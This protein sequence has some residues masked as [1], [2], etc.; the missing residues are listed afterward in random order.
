M[1]NHLKLFIA[2]S[3]VAASGAYAQDGPP[4]PGPGGH[5]GP[6]GGHFGGPGMGGP[7]MAGPMGAFG[8]GGKVVT[9]A[10]YSADVSSQ[11]VETLPDG[12]TITRSTTGKVARDSQGRTYT[13]ETISGGFMGANGPVMVT[14]ISDPVAGYNYALNAST[15]IATRMPKRVP[16][17]GAAERQGRRG[18]PMGMGPDSANVQTTD[19]GTQTIAGVSATGK[20]VTHTIPAGVM[21]NAQ[22]IISSGETWYSA[23]LQT[24][25]MAKHTDPRSGVSTYTLQNIVRAEPAATLFQVPSDY[26]VQD[27]KGGRPNFAGGPRSN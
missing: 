1:G 5:G 21:G 17:A 23:D 6:M 3:L 15:K 9:G 11:S 25:V 20:S 27:A 12:N 26:T 14:F 7:G 24:L 2:L 8:P 13:Q 4:P 10:P 22:P 18:G 19:L 16:P